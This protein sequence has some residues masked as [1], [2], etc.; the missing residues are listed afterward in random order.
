MGCATTARPSSKLRLLSDNLYTTL[1]LTR[2]SIEQLYR[3]YPCGSRC[4]KKVLTFQVST[5]NH[6]LII[7]TIGYH[8]FSSKYCLIWCCYDYQTRSKHYNISEELIH[9]LFWF[10]LLVPQSCFAKVEQLE[11]HL[12]YFTTDRLHYDQNLLSFNFLKSGLFF[13]EHSVFILKWLV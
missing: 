11:F 7:E 8:F 4:G 1:A 3:Y 13:T 10:F 12:I 6:A 2:M 5:L 9:W